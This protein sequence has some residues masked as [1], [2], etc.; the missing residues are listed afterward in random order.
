MN[1]TQV[2]NNANNNYA[3]FKPRMVLHLPLVLARH[4]DEN[5]FKRIFDAHNIGRVDH[6]DF[7]EKHIHDGDKE[8]K[9]Q[10]FVHFDHW[11]PSQRAYDLQLQ[12]TNPAI[13]ATLTHEGDYARSGPSVYWIL[14]ECMNPETPR[15]REMKKTIQRLED[16]MEYEESVATDYAE[17]Q[18]EVIKSLFELAQL[19]QAELKM[20]RERYGEAETCGALPDEETIVSG[21]H[22]DD[23][24]LHRNLPES[25]DELPVT[26]ME[27]ACD[28]PAKHHLRHFYSEVADG[29]L[30]SEWLQKSD[31]EK[32]T[33]L[34]AELDRLA[35]RPTVAMV[36]EMVDDF[37]RTMSNANEESQ[38][39]TQ[40]RGNICGDTCNL[41]CYNWVAD[42]GTKVHECSKHVV[43][44][45]RDCKKANYH[46]YLLEAQD[47]PCPK[48]GTKID[49]DLMG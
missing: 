7:V 23:F 27:F 46:D 15:E 26:A 28:Y 38:I 48:C 36:Q 44:E 32:T 39:P 40:K 21:M 11:Y 43:V 19:Q 45:C 25:H 10:A 20:L 4:A 3:D 30:S 17:K 33:E 29:S 2:N 47:T 31:E 18:N 49:A 12:I 24:D 5:Y 13:T 41:N 8:S 1:P 35:S 6:V 14:N 9:I 22:L 37:V 16:T 34:D 42:D